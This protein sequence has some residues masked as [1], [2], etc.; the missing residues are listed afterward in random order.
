MSA[1]AVTAGG[2]CTWEPCRSSQERDLV[3][4]CQ[5]EILNA[6]LTPARKY[7]LGDHHVTLWGSHRALALNSLCL[8][9]FSR[10]VC[11]AI[12]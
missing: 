11:Q 10:K 12:E 4:Y 3:S 9:A 8:K 7:T 5:P 6:L 1:Y 2:P